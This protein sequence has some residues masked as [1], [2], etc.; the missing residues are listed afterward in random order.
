M[1]TFLRNRR[2]RN[3]PE[4]YPGDLHSDLASVQRER[5]QLEALVIRAESVT[6]RLQALAESDATA[7]LAGLH[8]RLSAIERQAGAA[9][10]L[11]ATLAKVE[12]QAE[13][14]TKAQQRSEA[15]VSNGSKDAERVQAQ[16]GDILHKL[17]GAVALREQLGSFTSLEGPFHALRG[18]ADGVRTQLRELAEN[19]TRLRSHQTDT[20][21]AHKDAVG[22]LEALEQQYQGA[23]GRV[24]DLDRRAETLG[25]SLE[26]VRQLAEGIPEVQHQLGVLKAFGDQVSQKTAQLEQQRAAVER[27]AAQV[28]QLEELTAQVESGLRRQ[29]EHGRML[30]AMEGKLADVQALQDK[31]LARAADLAENQQKLDEAKQAALQSVADLREAL[32]SSTARFE[33]EHQGLDAVSE[34]VADLRGAVTDCEGR[35]RT[36]Q[37]WSNSLSTVQSQTRLLETQLAAVADDVDRFGRQADRV[38]EVSDQ[39]A[40]LDEVVED[41]TGR[42]GRAQ[43]VQPAVEAMVRD[44]GSLKTTHEALRDG[45]EQMRM[46]QAEMNRVREAQTETA[47]WLATTDTW[48]KSLQAQVK[49]L[50]GYDH[51]VATIRKNT[52]QVMESSQALE[53]RRGLVDDLHRRLSDLATIGGQIQERSESLRT[54]MEAAE[55]RFDELSRKSQDAL[56][57]SNRLA[58]VAAGVEEVQRRLGTTQTTMAG[59]EEGSRTAE[60]VAEQVRRLGEEIEQRQGALDKATD[61]LNRASAARQEAAET[62]Q[63]LEETTRSL[64]GSLNA[65]EERATRLDGVAKALEERAA[66]LQ[67]VD[68]RLGAFEQVLAKWEAAQAQADRAMEQVLA[69]Q[70]AMDALQAQVKDVFGAAERTMEDVRAISAGKREIEEV[71]GMLVSTQ[72]QLRTVEDAVKGL[73]VRKRQLAQAEVRLARAEALALELRSSLEAL[74][75]QRTVVDQAVERTG[76]LGFQMKQAEGLIEALREERKLAGRLKDAVETLRREESDL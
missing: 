12:E 7:A 75:V 63:R 56:Q 13:R 5:A 68:K 38:R 61:H 19:V 36:L 23:T 58:T 39:V 22:R 32:R 9:E 70:A 35:F 24:E 74:Q 46:A 45:L 2:S 62:A 14:L 72:G 60:R 31:V 48:A 51:T 37:A 65:A 3:E 43:E 54:R 57:V 66:G 21:R 15:Q 71:R 52:E 55:G 47:S 33:L 44:F 49:E 11:A 41:I 69:R 76:A 29:Q 50:A 25:R 30:S 27:A 1:V 64:T 42:V 59:L 67:G 8:D 6:A 53:A 28:G 34:R 40:K 20:A 16:I 73:D 17:D 10:R 18:E 4:T 26:E